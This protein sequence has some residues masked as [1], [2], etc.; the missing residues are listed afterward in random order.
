MQNVKYFKLLKDIAMKHLLVS[1]DNHSKVMQYKAKQKLKSVDATIS[2]LL[3]IE[4][5]TA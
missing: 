5:W 1:D 3:E 2:K 4:D